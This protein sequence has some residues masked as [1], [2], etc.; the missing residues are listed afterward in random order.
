MQPPDDGCVGSF[1]ATPIASI[2]F[3]IPSTSK[4]KGRK[5]DSKGKKSAKAKGKKIVRLTEE[6]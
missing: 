3:N 2:N 6:N 1:V 4:E 5:N